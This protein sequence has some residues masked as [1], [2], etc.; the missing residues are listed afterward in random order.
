MIVDPLNNVPTLSARQDVHNAVKEL[1]VFEW[2]IIALPAN[3]PRTHL[4]EV[5]SLSAVLNVTAT[6]SAHEEN[7]LVIMEFASKY[8]F[9]WLLSFISFQQ[10]LIFLEILVMV[11]AEQ[12]LIVICAALLQFAVVPVI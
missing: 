9:L 5:P 4:W 8:L 12:E 11:L 2:Q 6:Q 7:Q 3:V 1:L 10:F